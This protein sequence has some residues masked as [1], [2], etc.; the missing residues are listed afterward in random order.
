MRRTHERKRDL[1]VETIQKNDVLRERFERAETADLL[2]HFAMCERC[3]RFDFEGRCPVCGLAL[4]PDVDEEL[5]GRFTH[6]LRRVFG[7]YSHDAREHLRDRARRELAETTLPPHPSAPHAPSASAA[8]AA[9]TPAQAAPRRVNVQ[10]EPAR[11]K[12]PSQ[13]AAPPKAARA[14]RA[15]PPPP[16]PPPRAPTMAPPPP[17]PAPPMPKSR[18]P[19]PLERAYETLGI[20]ADATDEEV[21]V[22]F[23]EKA[24]ACHPDRVSHLAPEFRDLAEKQMLA[25]NQAYVEVAKARQAI[26]AKK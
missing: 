4:R 21:R 22:A 15:P 14:A 25:L 8:A 2:A 6:K 19:T 1:V 18:E 13:K 23:R 26:A 24:K 20:K 3:D 16:P 12:A 7:R 11:A 5:C 10:R 17:P 9:S